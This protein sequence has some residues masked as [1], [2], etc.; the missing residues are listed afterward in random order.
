MAARLHQ[1]VVGPL[2]LVFEWR[3][4]VFTLL[5]FPG[6]LYL[7]AWQLDRAAEK[8]ELAQRNAERQTMVALSQAEL[9]QSLSQTAVAT[10]ER[11]ALADR[12]VS[13]VGHLNPKDYLL[14]DNRI[15]NG[16]FGYEVV[17]L[18]ATEKGRVPVNLGWIE[19]DSA[20]RSL[21]DPNLISG[22]VRLAGRVY[23]PAGSAYLLEAQ[24]APTAFPAVVQNYDASK[25]ALPLSQL[26]DEAVLPVMVR[27]AAEDPHA[28]SANWTVVN[29]SPQKHTGYAVQ[30]FTMAAVLL[31]AF[32]IHS[33]NVLSLIRGVKAR[34]QS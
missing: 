17:A 7:G 9:F 3:L 34:S 8:R 10:T 22:E 20:R 21:P 6:L 29:Q 30:W 16:R 33:S 25:F 28:L 27:I 1:I 2:E 15:T 5:L 13:I 11:T 31:L 26:L 4:T 19:G 32:M 12:K 24:A 23:V 18:V 14:I